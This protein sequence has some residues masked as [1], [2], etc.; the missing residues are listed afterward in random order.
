MTKKD[1]NE[2]VTCTVCGEAFDEIDTA[3]G[4]DKK[5]YCIEHAWFL[6]PFEK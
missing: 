3:E 5:R 2:E 4:P 1:D 6:E